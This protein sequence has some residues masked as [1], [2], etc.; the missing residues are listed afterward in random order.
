MLERIFISKEKKHKSAKNMLTHLLGGTPARDSK[1]KHLVKNIF[2]SHL[3]SKYECLETMAVFEDWF[4]NY[5]YPAVPPYCTQISWQL[6]H[7][8]S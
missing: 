3:E 4:K 1:L 5:F 8:L 6:W 2:T 7:C